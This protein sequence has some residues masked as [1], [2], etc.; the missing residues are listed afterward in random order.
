MKQSQ[1]KLPATLPQIEAEICRRSLYEFVLRAWHVVETDAF[2][3]GWHIRAICDYLEACYEG[4]VRNLV[5]N[6]PPRHMKSLMVN[7]FFPAWVWTKDPAKK[8]LATS[9][10]EDLVSRDSLKCKKL[11]Q[12]NWYQERFNVVLEE[13]PST[14]TKFQNT[15]GGYRYA[16]GFGGSITGQGGDYILIDDP[17]KKHRS[18]Q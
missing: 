6:V 13:L 14:T 3:D 10:S 9:Y 4:R 18:R 17:L 1:A 5:I 12:S 11:V 7:V 16:F 2:V 8:F 15:A